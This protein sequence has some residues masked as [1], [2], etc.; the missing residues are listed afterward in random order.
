MNHYGYFETLLHARYPS[1][2]LVVRNTGYGRDVVDE[3]KNL[4]AVGYPERDK[5]LSRLDTDSDGKAN[6]RTIFADHLKDPTGFHFWEEGVIVTQPPYIM[7]LEDRDGDGKADHR[8]RLLSHI[9]AAD[10]HSAM[11]NF[12]GG[13]GGPAVR[14]E[15][16]RIQQ[17]R[18]RET[19]DRDFGRSKLSP[20]RRGLR[21]G[22]GTLRCRLAESSDRPHEP[23]HTGS[24]S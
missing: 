12:V 16:G 19:T 14:F 2:H 3:E 15:M 11:N 6:E 9:S 24:R 7:Y 13:Q 17:S 22:R 18:H 8:R 20:G 4:R 21:S 5:W 10:T 23:S 1:K